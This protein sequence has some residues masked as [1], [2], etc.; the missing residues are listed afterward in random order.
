MISFN[1]PLRK[2][3]RNHDFLKT[4][5][6]FK[7]KYENPKTPVHQEFLKCVTLAVPAVPRLKIG[8]KCPSLQGAGLQRVEQM[9]RIQLTDHCRWEASD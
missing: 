4:K 1:I 8:K 5:K 3:N 9:E 6:C 7:L 2:S